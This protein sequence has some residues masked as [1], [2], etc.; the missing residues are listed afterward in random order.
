MT[1]EHR[2]MT[3]LERANPV[4]V[5]DVVVPVGDRRYLDTA[6]QQRSRPMTMIAPAPNATPRRSA[7]PT[8]RSPRR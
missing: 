4:P 1:T 5:D 3:I 6:R 7:W 2:V 8:R